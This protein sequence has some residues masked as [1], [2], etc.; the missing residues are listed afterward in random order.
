MTNASLLAYVHILFNLVAGAIEWALRYNCDIEWLIR[1]LDD[2]L[3]AGSLTCTRFVDTMLG[4]CSMVGVVGPTTCIYFL[5][6]IMD[7]V[8]M[9]ARL[10]PEKLDQIKQKLTEFHQSTKCELLSLIGRLAFSVQLR[11]CLF[12]VVFF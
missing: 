9:E 5:G 11:L 6:I 12:C 10:P 2:F 8:K 3:T 7:T 1:Y 4:L